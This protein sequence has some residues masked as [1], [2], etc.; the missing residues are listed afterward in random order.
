LGP[1]LFLMY[2]QSISELGLPS[3][4]ASFAD[5]SKVCHKIVNEDDINLLQEDLNNLFDW[6]TASNMA[7]N[8]KKLVW[9]QYGRLD[10][11]KESYKYFSKDYNHILTQSQSTRDLGI[12]TNSDTNHSDHITKICSKISQKVGWFLRNI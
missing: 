9:V 7:F 11:L 2:I 8:L 6:E 3:L 5:D 10:K 12:I 1:I 4:L